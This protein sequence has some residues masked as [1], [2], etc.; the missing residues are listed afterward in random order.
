MHDPCR[1]LY[2]ISS[3]GLTCIRAYH[4]K[5]FVVRLGDFG[6]SWPPNRTVLRFRRIIGAGSTPYKDHEV[7]RHKALESLQFLAPTRQAHFAS[8]WLRI[9][10]THRKPYPPVTSRSHLDR[11]ASSS[12]SKKDQVSSRQMNITMLPSTHLLQRD[13]KSHDE[14]AVSANELS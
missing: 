1:Y 12:I 2:S 8:S 9:S 13:R 3:R 10:T 5:R 7:S 4:T 14:S 11:R 6:A